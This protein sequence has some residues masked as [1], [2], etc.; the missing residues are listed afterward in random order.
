MTT[1]SDPVVL[2][3]G[4]NDAGELR[5]MTR[6]EKAVGP[7]WARLI[8]GIITNPLSVTGIVLVLSLIHM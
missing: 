3:P 6:L 1:V 4:A 5:E 7:E 2:R 8:K